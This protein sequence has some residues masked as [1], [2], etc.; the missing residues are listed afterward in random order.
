[1][2]EKIW[3]N[4]VM[5]GPMVSLGL[6][7]ATFALC[8]LAIA[9]RI[10]QVR[11]ASLS[12]MMLTGVIGGS[13]ALATF[14]QSERQ[15]ARLAAHPASGIEHSAMLRCHNSP[16][17]LHWMLEFADGTAL[18]ITLNRQGPD[19]TEAGAVTVTG[20]ATPAHGYTIPAVCRESQCR[21]IRASQDGLDTNTLCDISG[22]HTCMSR[23]QLRDSREP[24]R[25]M[26]PNSAPGSPRQLPGNTGH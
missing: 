16:C 25:F 24:W 17:G 8:G 14:L 11:S 26:T 5:F 12:G 7:A 6:L 20:L 9:A 10:E 13:L 21:G 19:L 18:P 3:V 15:L 4:L 2:E 23:R 1:M 22:S